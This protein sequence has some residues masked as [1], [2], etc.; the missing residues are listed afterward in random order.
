MISNSIPFGFFQSS[1]A[2]RQGDPLSPYLFVVA[3]EAL[4]YPVKRDR[5]GES[6]IGVSVRGKGGEG[7][8]VSHF[9]FANDTL[10]FCEF[11]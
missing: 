11:S 4:S 1:K 2:L 6:L 5:E 7:Q 10:I 3:M 9:L 8:E